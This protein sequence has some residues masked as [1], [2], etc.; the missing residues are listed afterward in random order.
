MLANSLFPGRNKPLAPTCNVCLIREDLTTLWCEVTSSIRT[1]SVEDESL[2]EGLPGIG[3]GTGSSKNAKG[4]AAIKSAGSKSSKASTISCDDTPADPKAPETKE[5]LLCLRPIRDGDGKVDESLRFI[6][7]NNRR[8]EESTSPVP[9]TGL[10]VHGVEP[11]RAVSAASNGDYSDPSCNP[12]PIASE[13]PSSDKKRHPKKRQLPLQSSTAQ[14]AEA[15]PESSTA[16]RIRVKG[17]P[18]SSSDTEKSVV[19]SLML[20]SHKSN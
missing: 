8:A 6:P 13:E 15:C 14:G 12:E 9:S 2:D 5:L 10:N 3:N 19:E 11:S 4:P 16:K 7:R 18:S 1:R 17:G 20:M